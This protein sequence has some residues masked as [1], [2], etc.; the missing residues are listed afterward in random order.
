MKS[1][2]NLFLVLILTAGGTV[3]QKKADFLIVQNPLQLTI[4]NKYEQPVD[5]SSKT[6]FL[7][8]SPFQIL[9]KSTI[10]GDQISKAVEFQFRNEVYYILK[11]EKGGLIGDT[12]DNY[13][14]FFVGT[15]VMD[16][17]IT[18]LQDDAVSLFEKYGLQGNRIFLQKNAVVIRI[19]KHPNVFYILSSGRQ[20]QYGW[21]TLEP[22]NAWKKVVEE[23]KSKD[24]ISAETAV[25]FQSI[26]DRMQ[27]VNKIYEQY[28][29]YFNEKTKQQKSAPRWEC[30]PMT[31][32]LDCRLEGIFDPDQL[33]SSNQYLKQDIDNILIGKPYSVTYERGVI[34]VRYDGR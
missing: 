26:V 19:F 24:S 10:L 1:L 14:Q 3:A 4:F 8:Y 15:T 9:N 5:E 13:K 34:T 18:I 16:D 27:A 32:A 29:G 25:I 33:S 12:K 6:F 22:K 31:G 17:T 7:S 28:F 23:E 11:N 30:S 2:H 20:N 21:S